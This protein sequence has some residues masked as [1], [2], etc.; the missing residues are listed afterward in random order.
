MTGLLKDLKVLE[1]GLHVSAPYCTKVLA[2]L[3][4]D[5]IKVEPLGGDPSRRA[6]PFPNDANHNEKSG[7]FLALN[8]NKR[9]IVLDLKNDK[10]VQHLLDLTKKSDVIVD[11]LEPGMMDHYGIGYKVLSNVNPEIL[12]VSI[13]PFGTD[14]TFASY[15]ATDLILHH[16]GGLAHGL[17]GPVEDP[18]SEPPVRAGGH[19][20]DLV[21]GMA[22]AT[23]TMIALYSL[24][25]VGVGCHVTVSSFSAIAT[26][27]IAGLANSAFGRSAPTRDL[28]QQKEAA[29]GGMVAAIGGVLPCN[30]GYVAI[31]PREDAQWERWVDLMGNPDWA[32]DERFITRDG[33]QRNFPALWEFV[34]DWTKHRSKFYLA[35][36]GQEKRIPCFPVN[37]VEDLLRDPHLEERQFFVAIDHPM[38]GRLRYPGVPYKLSNAKLALDSRPAPLLGEHNKSILGS[39]GVSNE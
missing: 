13:T 32:N 6:G 35:R 33:R 24:R 36:K 8:S 12:A 34:G 7:L 2:N 22:A 10:D 14:G 39:Y 9:G 21:A 29:I 26:Q 25:T 11:N 37:T 19:Q 18:D 15:K 28:S 17:I 1:I 3:G 4:A 20:A 30:D 31:S 23:A 16:M 38:A 5:V 27:V